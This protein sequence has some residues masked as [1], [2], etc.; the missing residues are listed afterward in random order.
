M[1]NMARMKLLFI[2]MRLLGK[3]EFATGSLSELANESPFS[4]KFHLLPH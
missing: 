4:G 1:S 3:I 2:G